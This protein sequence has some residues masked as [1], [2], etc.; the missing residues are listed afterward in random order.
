MDIGDYAPSYWIDS[1]N[2]TVYIGTQHEGGSYML[3][4]S[5]WV[6]NKDAT[7]DWSKLEKVQLNIVNAITK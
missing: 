3:Y 6:I 5:T 4:K 7:I 1:A 2:Q